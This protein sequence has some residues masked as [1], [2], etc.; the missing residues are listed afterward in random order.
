MECFIKCQ[1][2][3]PMKLT[4]KENYF[5]VLDGEIPEYIP[6]FFD[7]YMEG[8]VEEMIA[9]VTAPNDRLRLCM[10]SN[11]SEVRAL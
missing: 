6:S 3:K 7:P 4:P 2:E 1:K 9:P 11:T 10:V 5:K 8:I